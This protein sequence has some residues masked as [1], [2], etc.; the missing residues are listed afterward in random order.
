VDRVGLPGPFRPQRM[1]ALRREA[2]IELLRIG[3]ESGRRP[4]HER[5]KESTQKYDYNSA[6]CV[7]NQPL[8]HDL[9]YRFQ[10]LFAAF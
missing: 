9:S 3:F 8:F 2:G 5:G 1:Y 4:D 6:N 10:L 7:M